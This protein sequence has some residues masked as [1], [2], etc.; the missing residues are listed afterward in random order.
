LPK[1]NTVKAGL[2]TG[3]AITGESFLA[4]EPEGLSTQTRMCISC[5]DGTVSHKI[6]LNGP[7]GEHPMGM[8]YFE[9]YEKYPKKYVS[10]YNMPIKLAG[11][12]VGCISCHAVHEDT[13]FK[14]NARPNNCR[15]C[16]KY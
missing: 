15:S 8:D 6:G 2:W 14:A 10:P 7:E 11:R 13:G 12:K 5:H 1:E 16:H 4:V 3:S 9:V